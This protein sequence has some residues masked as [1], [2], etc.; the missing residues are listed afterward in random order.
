ME[1][2]NPVPENQTQPTSIP[3]SS[4]PNQK[5]KQ[6]GNFL[7]IIGILVI[8][9]IITLGAYYFMKPKSQTNVHLQT[10]TTTPTL[11][12]SPTSVDET[13]NW[14]KYSVKS[15]GLN[16]KLPPSVVSLGELQEFVNPG[17]K[18]TQVFISTEN[19]KVISDKKF[20]MGTT[21]TDYMAG[22]GGMFIDL[23]GFTKQNGKYYAK[24]VDNKTIELPNEVVTE[25][26]NPSGLQ[27]IKI[28]GKN[29][30]SGEGQGLPITG[31][32][33]EGKI[34]A[35]INYNKE[36]YQG[37]AI[38]MDLNQNLTEQL[39]DQIL[40]TFNFTNE[41]TYTSPDGSFVVTEVLVPDY[42]KIAVKKKN[43]EVITEDL[44]ANNTKELGYNV[45]YGCMCAT[46]F[47]Q[48]INNTTFSIQVHTGNAEEYEFLVDAP[49]G[50]VIES[51]FKKVK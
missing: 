42:Y 5:I 47:K 40:S 10:S 24:F 36:S 37:L 27:I 23:Q 9:F 3:Q 1:D 15:L 20:L 18:G 8:L 14:K 4:T 7:P 16:Y 2:N 48:W 50:K 31:T 29:Y 30:A 26:T 17:Q 38:Q 19:S 41:N 6:K 44:V 43:G 39:F 51:S 35:L 12:P 28:K 46:S 21:S 33:G 49:T 22:R 45:K 13:T 34:G 32:P 25:V 11:Q